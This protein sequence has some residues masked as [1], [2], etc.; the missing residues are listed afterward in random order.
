M[1]DFC[2]CPNILNTKKIHPY[3]FYTCMK[4]SKIINKLSHDE[5]IF[6]YN[7]YTHSKGVMERW[8]YKIML[9][10]YRQFMFY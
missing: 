9:D 1:C 7:S 4:C 6:K 5:I 3:T 10:K 8:E 2:D